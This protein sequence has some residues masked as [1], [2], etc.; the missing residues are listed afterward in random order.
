MENYNCIEPDYYPEFQ[1]LAS[2]CPDTCC[3]GW[4]IELDPATISL[5]QE[6]SIT[7]KQTVNG[8]RLSEYIH[9]IERKNHPPR[10]QLRMDEHNYCPFLNRDKLCSIV[11]S[12][13]DAFT[14]HIC[15]MFPRQEIFPDDSSIVQRGLSVR[16]PA[17]LD[18]LWSRNAFSYRKP[19]AID[20][21][22]TYRLLDF[23]LSY[24]K[25]SWSCMSSQQLLRDLLLMVGCEHEKLQANHKDE[26][27]DYGCEILTDTLI[28]EIIAN[29]KKASL[30]SSA[31]TA[32]RK[33]DEL[34]RTCHDF[35]FDVMNSF[36][37]NV[38]F[39]S[40]F[41]ELFY[42]SRSCLHQPI[43]RQQEDFENFLQE[44]SRHD[45]LF[46]LLL[47]EELFSSVLTIEVSDLESVLLRLQWL[48]VQYLVIR[49]ILFLE[50]LKTRE[51]PLEKIRYHISRI[52]RVTD[53][54]DI[55][56]VQFFD[57]NF[58]DW[59]WTRDRIF[60]LLQ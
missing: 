48:C 23:M 60:L 24:A 12:H 40:D 51:L 52:F 17:V 30:S 18:L 59:V 16:C 37:D 21:R 14:S 56:K 47:T 36:F 20:E 28:T 39:A 2:A 50:W 55:I 22:P 53:L 38:I 6:H 19:A 7:Q 32:P 26:A 54:P 41:K 1:C 13:G 9:K 3:K 27:Y 4:I 42:R 8:K 43:I 5:W 58:K 45:H 35:M 15:R 25:N 31:A 44:F 57:S 33:T 11:G 34:L 29:A 46:K 10:Y 49:H